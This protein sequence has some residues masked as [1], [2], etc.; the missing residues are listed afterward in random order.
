MNA[1]FISGVIK[2]LKIN[3]DNTKLK[4]KVAILEKQ[5][6]EVTLFAVGDMAKQILKIMNV[7]DGAEFFA[8]VKGGGITYLSIYKVIPLLNPKL[9]FKL[10]K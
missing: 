1:C 6:E 5:Q 9:A 3:S 2:E 7:N 8:K 10:E 4:V